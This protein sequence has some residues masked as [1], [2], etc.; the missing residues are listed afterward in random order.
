MIIDAFLVLSGEVEIEYLNSAPGSGVAT[1]TIGI[2]VTAQPF[3][4]TE[5]HSL[6]H[7]DDAMHIAGT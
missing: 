7:T 5:G 1:S 3:Y 6:R 4:R 2:H